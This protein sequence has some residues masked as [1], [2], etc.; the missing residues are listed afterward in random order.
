[1]VSIESKCEINNKGTVCMDYHCIKQPERILNVD[2]HLYQL[3]TIQKMIELET[4]ASM[5]STETT[6]TTEMGVLANRVGSGKSLCVLGMIAHTMMLNQTHHIDRM[7]ENIG[8]ITNNRTFTPICAKN[9]IVVPNHIVKPIWTSYIQNFTNFSFT[10]VRKGMFPIDWKVIKDFDIVL[11]SATHYNIFMKSCPLYW[12]R[13]IFDE[14]DSI[15]ISACSQP[16]SR[17]V[18]FVT[19]SLNNLLFCDGYYWKIENSVITRMV[20]TGINKTGYIKNVF[21]CLEQVDDRKVL[22]CIIV[23]MS[24]EYI[25]SFFELAPIHKNVIVCQTPYYLKILHDIVPDKVVDILHGNDLEYALQLLGFPVDCKENIIS[26]VSRNLKVK[27]INLEKKMTYL[28]QLEYEDDTEEQLKRNRLN[29]VYANIKE[30]DKKI[31]KIRV[32]IGSVD[33]DDIQHICPICYESSKTNF[34]I[35]TCCLNVFCDICEVEILKNGMTTC[36]LCRSKLTTHNIV[37]TTNNVHMYKSDILRNML[38]NNVKD[39]KIVVFYKRDASIAPILSQLVSAYKILNGNNQT[40]LKTLEWFEQ[41]GNN[42]LFVNVELYGCGLNLLKTTDIIFFQ[43]M[44]TELENQLIGRA[45]RIGRL[46][47]DTLYIHRLLHQEE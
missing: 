34:I 30:V 44:S 39:K 43:K 46:K 23:K 17:F 33:I 25:N 47:Q 20:T 28:Q 1:M 22:E 24:D 35:H 16:I 19:S 15:N 26:F 40:I 13:V 10:I 21:K 8:Y 5:V 7:Y 45:Y 27:K 29:K 31:E 2:L 37:K 36:P 3:Q 11:C 41:N 14:A 6:L 18:W 38:F 12:S 32:L 9:L 4:N 42:V